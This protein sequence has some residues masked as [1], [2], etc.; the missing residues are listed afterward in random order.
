[1][2]DNEPVEVEE[3]NENEAPVESG[4]ESDSDANDL[5]N[6]EGTPV[7]FSRITPFPRIWR[8]STTF[9]SPTQAIR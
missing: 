5:D 3:T 1:M 7:F 9:Q 4:A 8:R 2:S 6:L